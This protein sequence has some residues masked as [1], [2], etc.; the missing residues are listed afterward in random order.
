M[1][2]LA[3]EGRTVISAFLFAATEVLSVEIDNQGTL[4]IILS[5]IP[6]LPL[7]KTP[8]LPLVPFICINSFLAP[9]SGFL[10]HSILLLQ[11]PITCITSLGLSL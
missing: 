5:V 6:Q 10:S 9:P 4:V 11:L 1:C 2:L 3:M 7:P 8:A